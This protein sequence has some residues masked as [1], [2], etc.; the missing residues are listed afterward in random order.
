MQRRNFLTLFAG[1]LTIKLFE[2]KAFSP[3]LVLKTRKARGSDFTF[4]GKATADANI[5]GAV[6]FK[7]NSSEM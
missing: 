7:L 1:I 3:R 6:K 2:K 4:Y 5:G